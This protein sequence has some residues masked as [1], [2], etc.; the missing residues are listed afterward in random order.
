MRVSNFALRRQFKPNNYGEQV[1]LIFDSDALAF[2]IANLSTGK[3]TYKRVGGAG[4]ISGAKLGTIPPGEI[5]H[6]DC[7]GFVQLVLYRTTI[8][9]LKL[10]QGSVKQRDWL[11]D[12]GY[13][14]QNFG[15]SD[16]P[17][18]NYATGGPATDNV[19]RI[20]FR[21]TL[22][23]SEGVKTSVGHVWLV[24]NGKTYESTSMFHN[25]GPTSRKWS[26]RSHEVGDFFTLGP[27]SN[28]LMLQAMLEI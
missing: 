28:F 4:K 22:R 23:N 19:V 26:D 11:V 13:K 20:G 6:L 3:T 7:S 25:I 17:A 2:L 15:N 14:P 27:A 9:Q 10:P 5:K 8:Q 12:N 21:D 16:Y 18:T 1:T 24:I